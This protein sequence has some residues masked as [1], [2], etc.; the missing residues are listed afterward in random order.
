MRL[1]VQQSVP[2][3]KS[4][5]CEPTQHTGNSAVHPAR[6]HVVGDAVEDS[7]GSEMST[8]AASVV[9]LDHDDVRESRL[10]DDT[11]IATETQCGTKDSSQL[12]ADLEAENW[13]TE[14][15]AS[16]QKLIQRCALAPHLGTDDV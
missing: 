3:Q 16:A 5:V 2:K 10:D 15:D 8:S 1:Q 4:A 13:L 11:E 7:Q 9:S 12:H 6:L 14:A